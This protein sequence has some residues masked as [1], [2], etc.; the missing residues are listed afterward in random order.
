[1][2]RNVLISDEGKTNAIICLIG[3]LLVC[4]GII[5]NKSIGEQWS[6]VIISIGASLIASAVIAYLTAIYLFKRKRQR[7]LT[8]VWGLD[9]IDERAF[10]L[11]YS[12]NH[13][14]Y[15]FCA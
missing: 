14:S 15:Q 7:E 5:F 2:K 4:I 10:I 1:M 12:C 13:R 11:N 8:E 3:L 9:I 6:T